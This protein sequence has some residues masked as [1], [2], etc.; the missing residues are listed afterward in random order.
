MI[1]VSGTQN[2][3]FNCNKTA[4]LKDYPYYNSKSKRNLNIKVS[5]RNGHPLKYTTYNAS[6]NAYNNI[7]VSASI[8][9]FLYHTE[10][11]GHAPQRLCLTES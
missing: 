8:P 10:P 6:T 5:K 4:D 3:Y 11:V 1:R 2:K 7:D 9:K